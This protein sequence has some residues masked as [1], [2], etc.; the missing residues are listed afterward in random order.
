MVGIFVLLLGTISWLSYSLWQSDSL[1][2]QTMQRMQGHDIRFIE[3][4]YLIHKTQSD[5]LNQAQNIKSTNPLAYRILLR[6]VVSLD[7]QSSTG[8]KARLLL[9]EAIT[10]AIVQGDT[11]AGIAQ[12]F[13][14][15]PQAIIHANPSVD[16]NSLDVGEV[17]IIPG[18]KVP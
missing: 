9:S 17:L 13:N 12:K 2:N 1:Y 4:E 10:Y 6:N 14:V 15:T 5:L 3:D 16:P 8:T 18:E 11:L 7:R